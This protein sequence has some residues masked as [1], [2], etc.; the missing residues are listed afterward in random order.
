MFVFK[1]KNIALLVVNFNCLNDKSPK[2]FT[3]FQ[4]LK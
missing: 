1:H 4:V 3:I 2:W